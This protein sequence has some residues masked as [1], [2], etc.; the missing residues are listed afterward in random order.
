[1]SSTLSNLTGALLGRDQTQDSA[2]CS[3]PDEVARSTS[4]T[5]LSVDLL[6][7]ALH[8]GRVNAWDWDLVSGVVTCT[9]NAQEFWGRELGSPEDFMKV[10]HD[11]DASSKNRTVPSLG[12]AN[13]TS[14]T[15]SKHLVGGNA[16]FVRGQRCCEIQQVPL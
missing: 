16:G 5:S 13:T 9:P 10:V 6:L 14:S 11:D 12:S 1:M 7:R 8:S 3:R 15:D 4:G 2:P